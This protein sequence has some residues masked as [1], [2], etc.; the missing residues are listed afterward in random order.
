[1]ATS[2]HS[3]GMPSSCAAMTSMHAAMCAK[4]IITQMHV[5]SCI[6]MDETGMSSCH[7]LRYLPAHCEGGASAVHTGP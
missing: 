6:M 5:A 4:S 2:Q 3:G 7:F 1:M